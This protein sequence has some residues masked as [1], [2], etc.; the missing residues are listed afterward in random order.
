MQ[1][2]LSFTKTITSSSSLHLTHPAGGS[3]PDDRNRTSDDL[4]R[5]VKVVRKSPSV[6]AA[7]FFGHAPTAAE[8][9][10]QALPE[11]VEFE[12]LVS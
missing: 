4:D 3:S 9:S 11:Q 12:V 6:R 10:L 2:T 1:L 8:T 5:V 7:R